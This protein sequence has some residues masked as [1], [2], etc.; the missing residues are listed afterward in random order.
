MILPTKLAFKAKNLE[1]QEL[2][3][4]VACLHN[5]RWSIRSIA[6]ALEISP[7]TATKYIEKG[8][9][10]EECLDGVAIPDEFLPVKELPTNDYHRLRS[11]SLLARKAA[12][13]TPNPRVKQASEDLNVYLRILHDE[14]YSIRTMAEACS[15]SK[16]AI[17]QRLNKTSPGDYTRE[18]LP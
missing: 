14:G 8:I 15:I 4:F 9:V 11:I 16:T 17:S 6:T 7:T 12:S 5:K 2:Y 3:D 18:D 13:A 1:G 10:S